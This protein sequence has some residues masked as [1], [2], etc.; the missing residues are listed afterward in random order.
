MYDTII[1]NVFKLSLSPEIE[2]GL[3]EKLEVVGL[4]P[5]GAGSESQQPANLLPPL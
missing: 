5:T 4:E 1:Q 3:E 2:R